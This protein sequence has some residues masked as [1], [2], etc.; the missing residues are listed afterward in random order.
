MNQ[1][2]T[3]TAATEVGRLLGFP[4]FR[5]MLACVIVGGVVLLIVNLFR[6]GK[7]Y[8]FRVAL[9]A[10]LAYFLSSP[11]LAT[12]FGGPER[13]PPATGCVLAF[14]LS[15]TLAWFCIFRP[16]AIEELKTTPPPSNRFFW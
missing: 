13:L 15:L 11:S 4:M 14:A 6:R 7:P 3:E 5:V 9:S 2:P 10:V 1:R 12:Q 16:G 8:L